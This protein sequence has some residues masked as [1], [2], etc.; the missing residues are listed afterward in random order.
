VKR[1]NHEHTI[2]ITFEEAY[3]GMSKKLSITLGKLCLS[4]KAACKACNGRGVF[5]MQMGPMTFPTACGTCQGKGTGATGC[6]YCN[7][8][9]KLFEKFNLEVQIPA[10]VEDGNVI[11]HRGMGEQADSDLE[12]PGDLI[13]KI[14]ITPHPTLMRMK[15]DLIWNTTISF[16]NSVNGIVV[17]VPHLDGPILVDTS[18]FGVI[19]PRKDY[20]VK[21][22][23]FVSGGNLRIMFDISYPNSKTK[24]KLE[25]TER[26]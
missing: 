25:C 16:E 17:T 3:R 4:C 10:G 8:K 5:H 13:F 23:G 26:L 2:N 15:R 21:D 1:A 7:F 6:T 12:E 24:F 20:I 9:C 22:K 14:Q 19:D 11:V 18:D